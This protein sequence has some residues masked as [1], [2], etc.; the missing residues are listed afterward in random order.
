MPTE[1]RSSNTEMASV[2]RDWANHYADLLEERCAYEQSELVKAFLAKPAEQPKG[3]PIQLTAVATLV[4]DADGG[5]EASWLLEGGTAELFAGMT[6]LVAENAPELCQEDGGAQV[7]THADPGEVERLRFEI[8]K[9][10]FSLEAHDHEAVQDDCARAE[11]RT[12]VSEV[13][14]LRTAVELAESEALSAIVERDD[15]RAQLA[16]RDAL[17]R[18]RSG[19]LI[20]MAAHLISAPLFALQELQD[21][22]KKMTR[23]RVDHAVDVADAR[24]KDAAYELRRIANALS[25]SAESS[26]PVFRGAKELGTACGKC[27]RCNE[28]A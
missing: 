21:E 13:E 11:N 18:D 20:R 7:Y 25:V 6:L 2:P 17:L 28:N 4:D 12:L 9:L 14:R 1:N 24:L 8:E 22:D 3:E 23:A 10:R 16:E 15:L 5:L 26:E 19:D 27:R